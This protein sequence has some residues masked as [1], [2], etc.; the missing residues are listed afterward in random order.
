MGMLED[1]KMLGFSLRCFLCSREVEFSFPCNVRYLPFHPCCRERR[2]DTHIVL[3]TELS[4]VCY[5]SNRNL[6]LVFR[7]QNFCEIMW[8]TGGWSFPSLDQKMF[9]TALQ[10]KR[11][12]CLSCKDWINTVK[13]PADFTHNRSQRYLSLHK[14]KTT[15]M[16]W[17]NEGNVILLTPYTYWC[18]SIPMYRSLGSKARMFMCMRVQLRMDV[19]N[20]AG[21]KR[22]TCS[23]QCLPHL[24]SCR[25]ADFAG[26][27][28]GYMLYLATVTGKAEATQWVRKCL[29]ELV[30]AA[31][32]A[33]K[34]HF[35]SAS[36]I[37][38]VGNSANHS[39]GS[40][41]RVLVF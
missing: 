18:Q 14:G 35:F 3:R 4:M 20:P 12:K 6:I 25:S 10:K 23:F 15:K 26:W 41:L 28:A 27:K 8:G 36:A 2:V 16:N 29:Q 39:F 13:F 24:C 30:L 37:Y 40:P 32:P 19:N 34:S 22:Y 11:P 21:A 7:R 31:S 38:V 17:S 5:F 9:C 33:A 1:H